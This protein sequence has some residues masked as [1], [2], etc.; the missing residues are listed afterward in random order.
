MVFDFE[1]PARRKV[2]QGHWA[3]M[4]SGVDDDGTLRAKRE[5]FKHI[6]LR[7]AACMTPPRSTRISNCSAQRTTARFI[8]ARQAVKNPF[9]RKASWPSR[10][11]P[12]RMALT[13]LIDCYFDSRR[14]CC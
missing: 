2:M 8:S 7:P 1:E 6:E 12:R 4:A 11:Q 3:Y 5:A 10:A 14:R 13:S 9:S